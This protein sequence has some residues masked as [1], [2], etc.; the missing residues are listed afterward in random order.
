MAM[1]NISGMMDLC[2]KECG[3]KTK[4][5]AEAFIFG[6]MEENTMANGRTIIC[7]VKESTP[8]KMAECTKGNTRMIA[9]TDTGH[10]HGTTVNNMQVGGKMES[11]TEK[12]PTGRMDATGKVYGKTARE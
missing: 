6:L 9:S 1:E 12:E 8:G 7:M 5:T 2:T 11:N 3:S 4:S 10:T